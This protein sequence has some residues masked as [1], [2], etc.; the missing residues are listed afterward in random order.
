[1][2]T[3]ALYA[4]IV[5]S[6][7]DISFVELL[8]FLFGVFGGMCDVKCNVFH[9]LLMVLIMWVSISPK[10]CKRAVLTLR[11][12]FVFLGLKFSPVFFFLLGGLHCL[13]F[14]Y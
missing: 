10:V 2:L 6:A 4:L 8:L 13:F 12:A 7:C 3:L 5:A 9:L 1:M 11:H 14:S